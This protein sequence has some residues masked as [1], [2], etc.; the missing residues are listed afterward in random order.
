MDGSSTGT[1]VRS[2]WAQFFHSQFVQC[3]SLFMADIVAKVPK[4]AAAIFRQ[5]TNQATIVDQ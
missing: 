5:K 1:S 3:M 4:N 2:F